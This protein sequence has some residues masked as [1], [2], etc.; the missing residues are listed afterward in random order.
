MGYF[1]NFIR[2]FRARLFVIILLN[3][4]LILADWY[5]IDRVVKLTGWWALAAIVIVPLITVGIIPW[6]ST[7]TLVKP[8][9]FLWQAIMHIAPG[10][11]S[12]MGAPKPEQLHLGRE[13][14]TNLVNQIYQLASV[15]QGV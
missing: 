9:K 15:V 12:T 5:I 4:A 6:L 1:Q 2:Q 10:T 3:N 7:N 8:T 14:V 11:A 13:L